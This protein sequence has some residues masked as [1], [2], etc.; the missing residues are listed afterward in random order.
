MRLKPVLAAAGLVAAVLALHGAAMAQAVPAVGAAV[1]DKNG[2]SLGVVERVVNG[3]DGRPYQVLV[4]QGQ[5]LRPLLVEGLEQKSG[6]F[7]TV[8]TRAEFEILPVAD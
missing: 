8:L 7:V 5:V 6:A 1:K 3:P 2:V 4:R